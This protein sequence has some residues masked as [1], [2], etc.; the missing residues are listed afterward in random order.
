MTYNAIQIAIASAIALVSGCGKQAPPAAGGMPGIP[1][2]QVQA[3]SEMV[4]VYIDEIGHAT[5]SESVTIQP[6]VSGKIIARH[7]VDGADIH[8]GDL[9]FEIDPR[10]Y[11]AAL[12]QSKGQLLKDTAQKVS[13]EWNVGQ[14]TSALQT[15]AISEQQLH[16]DTSTRDQAMAAMA[17]DEA[18]IDYAKLNLE[19]CYIHSPIDGRAGER[20]VD[21]GNVV[22]AAGQASGTSLLSIQTIDPIYADFTITEGELLKVQRYMK[23][24]ALQVQVMLPEDAAAMKGPQPASQPTMLAPGEDFVANQKTPGA[25]GVPL[26]SQDGSPT[27]I[28]ATRP[29]KTLPIPRTGKLIFLDNS[30]QD[31]SGTVRLRA[32]LPNADHHFWPGQFVNVRLV[33]ANKPSIMIPATAAQISQQGLFVYKIAPNDKSPTKAIAAMQPVTVGQRHGDMVVIESGLTAGDQIVASG[34]TMLQPD[35]PVMVLNAGGMPGAGGPPK[36][37]AGSDNS[38]KGDGKG[39]GQSM[40]G[41]HS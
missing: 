31:G 17:T 27:T 19:Y 29:A 22:T 16:N 3:V 40:E 1:V 6:Q 41:S 15:K 35:A 28:P 34:F 38:S 18:A 7:F 20:L 9:L 10:P 24:G 36:A 13:A 39:D 30:V 14:D 37:G 4:P 33:L 8:K 25:L 11:Q 21:V 2:M 26:P 32:E 5:A 12:E 23:L